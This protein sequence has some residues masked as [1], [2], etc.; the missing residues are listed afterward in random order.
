MDLMNGFVYGG[1]PDIGIRV[2]DVGFLDDHT[3]VLAFSSGEKRLFDA[4]IL[5]GPTFQR[6]MDEEVFALFL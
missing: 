1:T 4:R 3:M 6:L 5:D 2:T